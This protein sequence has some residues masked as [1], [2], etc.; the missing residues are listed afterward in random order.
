MLHVHQVLYVQYVLNVESSR[1]AGSMFIKYCM[2][3]KCWRFLRIF[4][5]HRKLYRVLPSFFLF[6]FPFSCYRFALRNTAHRC[7]VISRSWPSGLPSF[8][9]FFFT[10]FFGWSRSRLEVGVFIFFLLTSFC[11]RVSPFF[12]GRVDRES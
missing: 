12:Q 7:A 6:C 2:Y 3:G 1:Q 9:G 5:V 8:T 4:R 10:E 11:C